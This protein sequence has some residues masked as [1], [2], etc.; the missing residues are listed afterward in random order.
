M[1]WQSHAVS[2]T[3]LATDFNKPLYISLNLSSEVT[4]YFVLFI[5][6]IPN[7]TSLFFT[8][9]L[10]SSAGIDANGSQNVLA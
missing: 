8:K 10:D 7:P 3:P 1:N 4:F 5:K 6:N 2:C 9:I